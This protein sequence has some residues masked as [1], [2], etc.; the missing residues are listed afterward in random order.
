MSFVVM[1]VMYYSLGKAFAGIS[2][3]VKKYVNEKALVK[4]KFG[5]CSDISQ[6]ISVPL[7]EKNTR[8]IGAMTK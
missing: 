6:I 8:N 3:I 4:K 5:P 2:F 1:I 7:H